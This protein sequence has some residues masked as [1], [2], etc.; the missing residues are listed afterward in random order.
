[1]RFNGLV[2]PID[3]NQP[4]PTSGIYG[5]LRT[6]VGRHVSGSQRWKQRPNPRPLID[7]QSFDYDLRLILIGCSDGPLDHLPSSSTARGLT[8]QYCFGFVGDDR[9][10]INLTSALGTKICF[11]SALCRKLVFPAHSSLISRLVTSIA[12]PRNIDTLTHD[13]MALGSVLNSGVLSA[14]FKEQLRGQRGRPL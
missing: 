5:I 3:G 2:C 13:A 1:M 10:P 11:R 9:L 8:K 4:G 6:V 7:S 14:L 12:S